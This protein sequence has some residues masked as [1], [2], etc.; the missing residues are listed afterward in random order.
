MSL[1]SELAARFSFPW[2]PLV[3]GAPGRATGPQGSLLRCCPS[4]WAPHRAGAN[5]EVLLL[6]ILHALIHTFVPEHLVQGRGGA[7]RGF[8]IPG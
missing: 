7:V 2:S 3:R 4:L 8:P 1:G 5:P 6:D